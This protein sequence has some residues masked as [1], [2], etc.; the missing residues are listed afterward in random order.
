[1]VFHF[2]ISLKKKYL[3]QRWRDAKGDILPAMLVRSIPVRS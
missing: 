3:T 1:M 2:V